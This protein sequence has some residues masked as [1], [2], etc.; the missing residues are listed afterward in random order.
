MSEAKVLTF[1]SERV[2]VTQ[3]KYPAACRGN[4]TNFCSFQCPE[5][6]PGLIP[7]IT[8]LARLLIARFLEK[9][10][11]ISRY[12]VVAEKEKLE[13]ENTKK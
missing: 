1:D 4:E 7:F 3:G 6:A 11:R 10:L 12:T 13:N 8:Y 5:L 2:T 9:T